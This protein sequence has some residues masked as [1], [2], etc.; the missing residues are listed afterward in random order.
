[1]GDDSEQLV[2]D[3]HSR[4]SKLWESYQV[5]YKDSVAFLENGLADVLQFNADNTNELF[6]KAIVI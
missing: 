2:V 1:M 5:R 4:M 6:F 3:S